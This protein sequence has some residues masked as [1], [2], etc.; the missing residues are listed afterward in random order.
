[1]TELSRILFKDY[2]HW[3]EYTGYIVNAKRSG[4]FLNPLKFTLERKNLFG[5]LSNFCANNN[6]PARQW[7]FSLFAVRHWM[8]APKLEISHL[9]SSK[10]ITK[11][12]NFKDYSLFNKY[13]E[14]NTQEKR[15]KF[16]P[17]IDI[18]ATV[19]LAKAEYLRLGGGEL[20]IAYMDSETFGYHPKSTI[21]L[22]CQDKFKCIDTL[23]KKVKFNII[24]LR[25][26]I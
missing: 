21:C 7:L 8:F 14:E 13:L 22:S 10:H 3:R 17:N 19:E 5:N 9:C 26:G 23:I 12:Y 25:G 4:R 24:S 1:M 11:F 15:S 18:V 16:D 20:C 6:I 2:S